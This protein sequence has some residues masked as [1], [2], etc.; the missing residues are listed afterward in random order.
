MSESSEHPLPGR[1][2]TGDLLDRLLYD[3]DLMDVDEQVR[4]ARA[5]VREIVR[6]GI[7]RAHPWLLDA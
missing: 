4:Q 6:D 1:E 2:A 7:H 5:E 3:L